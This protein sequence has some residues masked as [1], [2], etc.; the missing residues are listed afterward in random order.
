[1]SAPEIEAY[2]ARVAADAPPL[3]TEQRERLAA[4]L[5]GAR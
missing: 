2:V 1:M 3:T 5:A 4:L